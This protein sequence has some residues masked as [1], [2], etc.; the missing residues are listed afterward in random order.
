MVC[1]GHE[2]VS[3]GISGGFGAT[4]LFFGVLER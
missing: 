2:G 4:G 3:Q 1:K